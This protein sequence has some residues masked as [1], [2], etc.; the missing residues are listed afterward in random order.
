MS[1]PLT[2]GFRQDR[3]HG[4]AKP[5]KTTRSLLV[6]TSGS[7]GRPK[8]VVLTQSALSCNAEMS[9]EAHRLR[10][11]ARVLNVLPLFH[12]GGL[13]ILPTPAFSVGAT[14]MLH[15]RFDPDAA[16]AALQEATH[17]ITVPTVL[18][19]I[20]DT[21]DWEYAD[22]SSLMSISIGSTDVPVS[23]IQAVQSRGVPVTQIYGATETG[24][25]AI[26]QHVDEAVA[27]TGSIG[28]AGS[29]CGIRIVRTAGTR[30]MENRARYGSKAG[31]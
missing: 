30:K 6:F 11:D 31:T 26:Y 1:P 20:I 12:V 13:N 4:G 24:P 2:T 23:L 3:L 16:C 9:V 25:L 19:A 21:D 7:T 5:V 27:T 28:R 10:P 22:L 15:E 18:Q 8:G 14:V 29:K 17:A